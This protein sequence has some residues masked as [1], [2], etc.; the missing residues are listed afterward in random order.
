MKS[1]FLKIEDLSNCQLAVSITENGKSIYFKSHDLSNMIKTYNNWEEH[2]LIF[3][4]PKVNSDDYEFAVF[5]WNQG[6]NQLFYDD[7]GYHIY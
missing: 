7:F 2:S 4:L 3:N 6:K 1:H 5:I